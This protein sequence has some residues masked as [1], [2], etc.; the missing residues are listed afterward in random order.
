MNQLSLRLVS[1][2]LFLR[3]ARAVTVGG[4]FYVRDALA[5]RLLFLVEAANY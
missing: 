2:G 5:L 4:G 1:R 3:P